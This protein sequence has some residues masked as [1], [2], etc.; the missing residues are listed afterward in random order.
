MYL[1]I[2]WKML[3]RRAKPI[4]TTSVRISGILLYINNYKCGRGPGNTTWRAEG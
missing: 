3:N 1:K 4:R 2:G